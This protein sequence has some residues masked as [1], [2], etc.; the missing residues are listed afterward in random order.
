MAACK[1]AGGLLL[2]PLRPLLRQMSSEVHFTES[3]KVGLITLDRQKALNAINTSMVAD[4]T[5]QLITWRSTPN[6][7]VVCI[8]GAGGKAFCAG[9]DVVSITKDAEHSHAAAMEFFF[10]EFQMNYMIGTYPTTYVALIHGIT[11]G[12]GVGL[13]VHG[14]Y[15]VATEKSLYAMPETAIGYFPDVGGSYFLSRL[16]Q[17]YGMFLGLTGHR[18]RGADLKHLGI[19]THYTESAGLAALKEAILAS[20]S[21]SILAT[22]DGHESQ[23]PAPFSLQPHADLIQHCF[24]ADTVQEIMVRLG[25]SGTEFAEKLLKTLSRMSPRSLVITHKLLTLAPSLSYQECFKMEYAAATEVVASGEFTEGVRA[26]LVDK[27]NAPRWNPASLAEVTEEMVEKYFT[28]PVRDWE[29][30]QF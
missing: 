22:L 23:L 2:R 27:D 24:S 18:L 10:K 13:S 19:A 17:C 1:A 11:M 12:G 7:E 28:N 5:R 3:P 15:R 9:G 26:L 4:I 25:E 8:E 20:D 30:L 6:V 29:P 21:S 14:K 16:P